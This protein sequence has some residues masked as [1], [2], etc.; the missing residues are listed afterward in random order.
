[1]ADVMLDELTTRFNLREHQFTIEV[2]DTHL[3][4]ISDSIGNWLK[5][6]E[7]LELKAY[8]IQDIQTNREI[9]YLM[10]IQRVL[11][12]WKTNN[13]FKATY[14]QLATVALNLGDS[15]TAMRVCELCKDCVVDDSPHTF[16]SFISWL[17][18][19]GV[20]GKDIQTLADE[21]FSTAQCF[22]LLLPEDLEDMPL[23]KA[24]K[25]LLPKLITEPK[26]KKQKQPVAGATGSVA[27]RS[28]GAVPRHLY[29]SP[30]NELNNDYDYSQCDCSNAYNTMVRCS[31]KL[32]HAMSKDPK[33]LAQALY[34]EG[35][36]S[37]A[38][39][40][41]TSELNETRNS[42]GSRLYS[43]VLG[44]VRSFPRKFADFV[45]ILRRDRILYSD[46]LIEIDAIYHV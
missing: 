31:V 46:V 5:Y 32:N 8:Q 43:A 11:R 15:Q 22:E 36:I 23:T 21:G 41:E 30:V 45:Q 9:D 42:K 14:K 39:M 24:G 44:R 6:A 40:D 28:V 16:P 35:F 7:A 19:K 17:T 13:A 33:A 1:M 20:S 12:V 10:R 26:E 27:G 37:Q 34:G 29:N 25:R 2:S 18:H 4:Q 38:T 3:N